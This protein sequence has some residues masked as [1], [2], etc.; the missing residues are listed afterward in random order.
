MGSFPLFGLQDTVM[1][2]RCS[3]DIIPCR[4]RVAPQ[5]GPLV[6]LPLLNDSVPLGSVLTYHPVP[7]RVVAGYPG[8]LRS[9]HGGVDL[10]AEGA[11]QRR[12]HHPLGH[13]SAGITPPRRRSLGSL[14]V[15]LELEATLTLV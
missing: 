7:A 4:V 10:L 13:V 5:E 2:I 11:G 6:P 8:V 3:L 14:P 1:T 12:G 15:G 9:R